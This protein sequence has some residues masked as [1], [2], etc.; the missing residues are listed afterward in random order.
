MEKIT[1]T[2]KTN[3]GNGDAEVE[4]KYQFH[5]GRN[6]KIFCDNPEPAEE[7][8]IEILSVDLNG[9]EISDALDDAQFDVLIEEAFEN[10]AEAAYDGC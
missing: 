7:A 10:N 1:G 6:A 4:V 9:Q 5:P 8:E 3:I 2:F